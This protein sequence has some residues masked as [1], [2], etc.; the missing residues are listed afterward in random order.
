MRLS[1]AE[2]AAQAAFDAIHFAAIGFVIVAGEMQHAVKD[3]DAQF[4][5]QAAIETTGVAARGGGRDGDVAGVMRMN[6]GN[7]AVARSL[8]LRG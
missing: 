8:G 2:A 7:G 5:G 6:L 1:E 4:V 3:Q